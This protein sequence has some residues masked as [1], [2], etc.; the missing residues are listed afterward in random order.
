MFAS[1]GGLL[2]TAPLELLH[3]PYDLARRLEK[4][5]GPSPGRWRMFVNFQDP[6]RLAG[7][8]PRV[9][10]TASMAQA[11]FPQ[12]NS[13]ANIE[14]MAKYFSASDLDYLS[15]IV[16]VPDVF[17]DLFGVRF[18]VEMPHSISSRFAVTHGF[19]RM[20]L[21]YWVREFP[22]G[23]RA[24]VV[25]SAHRVK[26]RDGA[27]DVLTRPGF[28]VRRS[29]VLTGDGAPDEV[30][31]VASAALLER[32]DSDSLRVW[33]NGPGMLVIGEH[34]DAGWRA[35]ISGAPAPIFK[36]DLAALGVVLPPGASTVELRFV[37]IG[38]P[39]GTASA[40]GAALALAAIAVIR[41]R[42][43]STDVTSTST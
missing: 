43:R 20:G 14:G 31:G 21:G 3:G 16:N 18:A 39:G 38:L 25:A 29:S 10:V 6:M 35:T 34:Y 8:P 26:D 41:R 1:S 30:R 27:L 19:K 23:S 40:A 36:A 7:V 28:S 24:F 5:A 37:P 33:A 15:A 12:F 32:V 13:I 42:E 17:F 9:A 4:I 22:V 11:L 2:Y